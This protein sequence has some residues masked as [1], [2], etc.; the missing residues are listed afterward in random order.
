MLIKDVISILNINRETLRSWEVGA[1]EPM[2]YHYP[3]IIK[4]LC[5]LPISFETDSLGG[6]IKKY[7]YLNGLSQEQFALLLNTDKC[8]VSFWEKNKRLP[9]KKMINRVSTFIDKM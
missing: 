2:P 9:L 7:R 4:F 5:Y 6:R 1:Y 8:T 3:A